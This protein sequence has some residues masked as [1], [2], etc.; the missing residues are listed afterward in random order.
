M[1]GEGARWRRRRRRRRPLDT[2][3][4]RPLGKGAAPGHCWVCCCAPQAGAHARL[5]CTSPL[6]GSQPWTHPG[7]S[8]SSDGGAKPARKASAGGSKKGRRPG[9]APAVCQVEGCGVNLDGGKP[10]YRLQRICG[11]CVGAVW[12]GLAQGG[13]VPPGLLLLLLLLCRCGQPP[14][15]RRACSA[16]AGWS[17]RWSRQVPQAA[18][19]PRHPLPARAHPGPSAAPTLPLRHF[20]WRPPLPPLAP[21][22]A[23]CAPAER[24]ARAAV[25]TDA[26]GAA[27]RF[28]QQC[29][30]L[31]P[32]QEFEG[33]KRSCVASLQRRM[34]RKQR[35]QAEDADGL[36]AVEASG[37]RRAAR[38]TSKGR[39]PRAAA[40]PAGGSGGGRPDSGSTP[41]D[42]SSNSHG[43]GS[44][45]DARSQ[46]SG[47]SG[48]TSGGLG[49]SQGAL[50]LLG[51]TPDLTGVPG[52]V[53]QP[54][55]HSGPMAAS[56]LL[57]PPLGL[58]GSQPAQPLQPGSMA[59][60]TFNPFSLGGQPPAAASEPAPGPGPR[61]VMDWTD[62]QG[63]LSPAAVRQLLQDDGLLGDGSAV[64]PPG[65]AAAVR[66]QLAAP[67]ANTAAAPGQSVLT[68][69]EVERL[70]V[71]C[72]S[73]TWLVLT[74]VLVKRIRCG[75]RLLGPLL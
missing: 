15:T 3:H 23:T 65:S 11:A 37:K 20:P 29:T 6:Q 60:G 67:A 31:H 36:A 14:Y 59:S 12:L 39:A 19:V 72:Y 25:I 53:P 8:D 7:G 10:F 48:G 62:T 1:W 47:G 16:N 50:P 33:E 18:C 56:P 46:L 22:P 75:C 74:G 9:R 28:C 43:S 21:T 4:L 5:V 69:D 57:L 55:P 70:L 40:A 49:G 64:P 54:L 52:M 2:G 68:D 35:Q 73:Y 63:L 13:L 38:R 32:V 58:G 45:G 30:R 44:Y 26:S 41:Y 61:V 51:Q 24:H 42:W 34:A 17:R 27:L 71:S 66:P